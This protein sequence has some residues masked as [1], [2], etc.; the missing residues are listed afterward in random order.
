MGRKDQA[1][2]TEW[3]VITLC[4]RHAVRSGPRTVADLEEWKACL[5]CTRTYERLNQPVKPEPD[6]DENYDPGPEVDDEGGM[7]EYRHAP[8][9]PEPWS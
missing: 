8:F 6:D 2:P 5:D 4:A 3:G 9:E 7:S 1:A